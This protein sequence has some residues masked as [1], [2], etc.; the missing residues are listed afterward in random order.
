MLSFLFS[1]IGLVIKIAFYA[2]IY[3]YIGIKM[4]IDLMSKPFNEILKKINASYRKRLSYSLDRRFSAF[5]GFLPFALFMT[6]LIFAVVAFWISARHWDAHDNYLID[7]IYNTTLGSFTGF[8]SGGL[9]FTPATIVAIAF[10]GTLMSLC[11]DSHNTEYE[12][13]KWY[14]RAPCYI[15]YLVAGSILALMLT[16]TFQT[17]GQWGYDTIVS[18]YQRKTEGF[19]PIVGKILALLP[20][21]YMALLLCLN[22]VK[23]Y[24]ESLLFGFLGMVAL[25]LGGWLLTYLPD[26]LGAFKDVAMGVFVLG[27]FF[28]LDVLQGKAVDRF[29][30][31]IEDTKRE[32]S[33]GIK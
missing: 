24:A 31:F 32:V 10:S 15:V 29:G 14:V 1:I 33:L 18:L 8:F 4:L 23:T 3:L 6:A 22:A 28:G 19:F 20:L 2:V 25:V 30:K 5:N 12:K 7:M 13:A 17:V 27:M 21:C 16:G 11:M 9:D 26:T